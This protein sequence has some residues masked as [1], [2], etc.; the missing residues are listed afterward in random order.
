MR[1]QDVCGVAHTFTVQAAAFSMFLEVCPPFRALPQPNFQPRA[2]NLQW[3]PL[4]FFFKFGTRLNLT[5]DTFVV[6]TTDYTNQI[7]AE[8]IMKVGVLLNDAQKAP[9]KL[10]WGPTFLMKVWN[11]STPVFVSF[12]TIQVMLVLFVHRDSH[13]AEQPPVDKNQAIS[14]KLEQ[15][16]FK[17]SHWKWPNSWNYSNQMV[18][19]N[20]NWCR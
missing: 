1:N 19:S 10:S 17:P 5:T 18:L 6:T 13:L 4:F 3:C 11:S 8:F 14:V 9:L 2:T 20:P 12:L 16:A 7:Q 15:T